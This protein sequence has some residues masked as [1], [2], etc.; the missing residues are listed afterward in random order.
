MQ[1]TQDYIDLLATALNQRTGVVIRPGKS[2]AADYKQGILEYDKRDLLY[3]PIGVVR[4]FLIHEIGHLKFTGEYEAGRPY[5]QKYRQRYHEVMNCSEDMRIESKL[6]EQYGDFA[7]SSLQSVNHFS[8]QQVAGSYTNQPKYVQILLKILN[9][10]YSQ[11]YPLIRHTVS[12]S[13]YGFSPEVDK[14]YNDHQREFSEVIHRIRYSN[15]TI[16]MQDIVDS[17]LIPLIKD[18][19]DEDND[20]QEQQQQSGQ[21]GADGNKQEGKPGKPTDGSQN[22][23]PQDNLDNKNP[24]SIIKSPGK[25]HGLKS[26]GDSN[27]TPIPNI[28]LAE[29]VVLV[30]PY[31]LTLAQRLR[32]VLND[33]KAVHWRG[34]HQ[35]GKL[36]SKNA[37][38]VGLGD[39]RIFSK[40]TEPDTPY[41]S[42]FMAI[43][44]SGSMEGE[45]AQNA[46]L[47]ATLLQ[48]ASKNL[49]FKLH[50]YAFDSNC[51]K[52]KDLSGYNA[53]G[54]STD[55]YKAMREFLKDIVPGEQ[56]IA[57]IVTDGDVNLS[58][59]RTVLLKKLSKVAKVYGIG[60]G[61]SRIE[62]SIRRAYPNPVFCPKVEDIPK[63]LIGIMRREIH[64]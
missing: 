45:P 1:A 31:A 43:D 13:S 38:K 27:K 12:A 46:L 30:R 16:E 21:G 3:L 41:Y 8:M 29:A 17:Q 11:Q 19:L 47:G 34:N 49:K 44:S 56:N 53:T 2:W 63:E 36:L 26:G 6:V 32:G 4:G 59:E 40:K 9:N 57:F 52:L 35:S 64:R 25:Y 48:E 5:P 28:T 55:D 50:L 18:F 51:R 37:Y 7:K 58:D 39:S 14:L 33:I 22:Q 24:T 20:K 10:Y 15:S 60:I 42:V 54:G 61:D 23:R 62:Q